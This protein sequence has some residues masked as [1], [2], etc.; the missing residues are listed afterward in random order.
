MITISKLK[1]KCILTAGKIATAFTSA[2]IAMNSF[3]IPVYADETDGSG[4][5]TI[6]K[7][8]DSDALMGGIIDTVL[9]VFQWIGILLLVWGIGQLI[10]AFKNE[11]ADSKSRAIMMIVSSVLL[12]GLKGLLNIV[13]II[14]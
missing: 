14:A 12:I 10:M 9:Q 4:T 1:D 7:D 13:G 5:T 8:L 3:M 6:N 11:D 2:M